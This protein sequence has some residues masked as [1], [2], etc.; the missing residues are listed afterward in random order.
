MLLPSATKP[1]KYKPPH[2]KYSLTTPQKKRKKKEK[3]A[4]TALGDFVSSFDHRCLA[5]I[6]LWKEHKL[7]RSKRDMEADMFFFCF[8]CDKQSEFP[9]STVNS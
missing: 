2:V 6:E 5:F 9:I 1:F 8:F 7:P 3:K 4:K